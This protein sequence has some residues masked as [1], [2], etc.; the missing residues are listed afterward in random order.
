MKIIEVTCAVIVNGK[1]V[2]ACQLG[3]NSH[4]PFRWEFPGG[5]I[6]AGETAES[7]IV[8]EIAE[9][10]NAKFTIIKPLASIDYQYPNK[11]IRL[12]PFLGSVDV[13]SLRVL[14]HIQLKWF[15]F[16]QVDEIYWVEADR[17]LVETNKTEL[18]CCLS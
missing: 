4:H 8:R 16:D 15:S 1:K 13:G 3:S 12:I 7:C 18:L 11:S 17:L 14:E 5:K 9:E 2:L 6:E 10:L